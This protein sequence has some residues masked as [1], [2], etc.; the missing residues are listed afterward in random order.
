MLLPE[1]KLEKA[2]ETDAEIIFEI[3]TKAF[4]PLL[5]KYKDYDTNPA[6]ETIDRV[7]TRINNPYGGFYKIIVDNTTVGAICV[8]WKEGTTQFWISPMFI[9][10][11]FQGQGIAQKAII[12]TEKMFPY[13]TS[14]E[15]ATILE[16][17]RNCYLYEKMDY[18]K[19]GL[20]KRLNDHTTLVFY[21]KC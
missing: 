3:Q 21:K 6:N 19:T 2:V 4:I 10:P 11:E 16:E 5:E 15:L 8:F 1:I 9:L 14:W 13:A 12:L 18:I 17:K 20:K 7:I